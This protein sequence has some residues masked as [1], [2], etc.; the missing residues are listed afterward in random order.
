MF[1][2][3][4]AVFFIIA[5]VAAALGFTEISAEASEVARILFYI[6]LSIFGL[7]LI[8]GFVLYRKVTSLTRGLALNDHWKRLVRRMK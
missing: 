3:W 6:S 1:F 7:L 8:S 4:A 2:M 5:L